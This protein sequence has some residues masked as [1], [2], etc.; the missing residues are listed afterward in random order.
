MMTKAEKDVRDFYASHSAQALQ[1]EILRDERTLRRHFY[2][3]RQKRFQDQIES[4]I[5]I[6]KAML[7]EKTKNGT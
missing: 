2:S 7:V 4:R 6:L 1:A 3:I 5:G